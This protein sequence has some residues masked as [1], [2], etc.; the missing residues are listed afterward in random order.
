M[1]TEGQQMMHRQLKRGRTRIGCE[2]S[3]EEVIAAAPTADS[4]QYIRKDWQATMPDWANYARCH[5]SILLQVPT[6]NPVEGW[7]YALKHGVMQEMLACLASVLETRRWHEVDGA[8]Y[9]L[10]SRRYTAVEREPGAL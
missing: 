7:H 10:L 8:S 9:G 4:Q 6:T 5:S 1:N 2:Q 3:A